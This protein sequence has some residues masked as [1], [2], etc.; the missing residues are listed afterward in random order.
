MQTLILPAPAK[1][2]LFLHITGRR[3][4]GYHLLQTLFVFLDFAD[5]IRLGLR[6]DGVIRRPSGPVGVP[7]DTDLVVRAARLLQQAAGC[8][9]GA[10]IHVHK[11]IPMGGG[12]GGGSSDAATVLLGLNHLWQCGLDIDQLAELGVTLGADVPV[13]VRGHAAWAEGIGEQ[14]EP[15]TLPPVWY[16][17][18]HPRVAVPTGELFSAQDLTRNSPPITLATFF[19]GEGKNAFQPVVEKRYPEV[20]E[21]IHWLS[22]YSA[23][24]LTGSGSCLFAPVKSK[25]HGETILQEM[26]GKWFGFV[27]EGL[28]VSPLHSKLLSLQ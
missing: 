23:A 18:I 12:L 28:S 6:E 11:R 4:D 3:P 2:N 26:P 25:F 8:P 24:R 13:F 27:A 5:E 1:L 22:G 10:D 14:L 20:A 9:S 21:A 15:V 19:S 7:E 16:V 17:V